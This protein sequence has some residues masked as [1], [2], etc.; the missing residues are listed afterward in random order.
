M[1]TAPSYCATPHCLTDMLS[2]LYQMPQHLFNLDCISTPACSRGFTQGDLCVQ[3]DAGGS[4]ASFC[5]VP[6]SPNAQAVNSYRLP[7][8][9]NTHF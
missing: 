7:L 9:F 5:S 8:H 2:V 3:A 1:Q 4:R 6:A